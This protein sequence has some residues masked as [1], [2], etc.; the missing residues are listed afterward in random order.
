M[1]VLKPAE[2]PR[3]EV[4]TVA[5][6][7]VT[8][9]HGDQVRQFDDLEPQ[10]TY[11]LDGHLVTTLPAPGELLCRFATVNDVHF[12]EVEAGRIDGLD[13]PTFGVVPGEEPYPEMMNRH[14]VEE[15]AAIDPAAVLIKGDLTSTG[16]PLE[17]AR[18]LEVYAGTFGNKLAWTNGNH[19]N[20]QGP[21][22]GVEPTLIDLPGVRLLLIDTS[23]YGRAGGSVSHETLGW[24]DDNAKDCETPVLLFGHHHV[25]LPGQEGAEPSDFFG[26]D[27]VSSTHLAQ[28][29][30]RRPEISGYFCGHT[31][32]NHLQHHPLTGDFPW[33]E[34]ASVKDFPGTWA[35]YRVFEGGILQIHRRIGA[36]EALAWSNRCRGLYQGIIDY[37][38]YALGQLSDRCFPIWSRR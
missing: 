8:F 4:T 6:D 1:S 10:R 30:A 28:L 12:G 5:N 26:I 15:I 14:A 9:H 24:I 18:C 38:E 32:R 7:E 19:D 23:D 27:P 37:T 3:L 22:F 35:E 20:F 21:F 17:Y 13:S 31:H 25:C 16:S 11:N 29:V 36:P 2:T 33:T 34:V